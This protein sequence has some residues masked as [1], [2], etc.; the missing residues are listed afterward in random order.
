MHINLAYQLKDLPLSPMEE[1]HLMQ[2]TREACQNA[3]NHSDGSKLN[4]SFTQ[5]Q[6]K[7]IEL[8]IEDDG[9]GLSGNP[10]K[11]NHYGL[12]IMQERSRHLGGD[13]N[14]ENISP[15]GTRI[16]LRFTP[17]YLDEAISA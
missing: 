17:A 1:I 12:S 6:D 9:V 2:I 16:T 14:I 10:E 3:I 11:L 8:C 13:L 4:I 5:E 15:S 7:A